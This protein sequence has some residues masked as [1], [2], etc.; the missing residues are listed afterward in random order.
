MSMQDEEQIQRIAERQL[1]NPS[2]RMAPPPEPEAPP[3]PAPE[4]AEEQAQTDAAPKTEA[5]KS[6]QDPMA[7]IE[8][9]MQ[10]Q[11]RKLTDQ[12]IA[13]TYDRYAKLNHRHSEV[14]PVMQVIDA[15]VQNSGATPGQA[16]QYMVDMLRQA[17]TKNIT[18]GGDG[19]P[20]S[21]PGQD[22]P[23]PNMDAKQGD[24]FADWEAENDAT[25]PPGYRE[26]AQQFSSMNSELQQMKQMLMGVLNSA[27]STSQEAVQQQNNAEAMRVEAIQNNIRVNID[28]AANRHGISDG[29]SE[30]FMIYMAERGFS[31][32]DFIDPSLADTVMKDF[33]NDRNG[34]ELEQLRK[35]HERR[36]AYKGTMPGTP[37]A[38][39]TGGPAPQ[40]GD[41]MINRMVDRALGRKVGM[42]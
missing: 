27:R 6:D 2:Q 11:P 37:S 28:N 23:V 7:F 36:V 22:T 3:A 40:E 14:K 13:S 4:T 33:A 26:Q 18:M 29:D 5:D 38:G 17:G 24:P 1:G 9:Q 8:I 12:Q 39:D 21:R 20:S 42:G 34:P 19:V 41:P 16:A 31:L 35:I 25:L 32:E 15:L 10:G 30:N